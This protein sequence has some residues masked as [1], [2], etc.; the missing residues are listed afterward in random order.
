[1]KLIAID[2]ETHKITEEGIELK[3]QRPLGI[4]CIGMACDNKADTSLAFQYAFS[5]RVINESD[6]AMSKYEVNE[7]IN[8]MIEYISLGYQ[9]VTWNG[10]QFDFDIIYEESGRNPI[11]KMMA[12]QNHIDLMFQVLCTKGY[13]LGLDT[14]C[15]GMG[16]PGKTEGMHGDLAPRMW[17]EGEQERNKVIDYCKQDALQTLYL[18]REL[19]ER[20]KLTWI[21]KAGKPQM[22][23][24]NELLTVEKCLELPEP[25]TSW[26]TNP[27]KRSSFT[28]W[29]QQTN[30]DYE[31]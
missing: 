1:M 27:L 7:F 31:L 15:K 2:I 22:M 17:R 14:A 5:T 3:A 26:M 4:T 10:L 24:V 23:P 16:L 11:V 30:Q 6:R 13:P 9:I 20:G 28:E 8:N 25:D 18:A 21:S 19:Q 12:L 29:L